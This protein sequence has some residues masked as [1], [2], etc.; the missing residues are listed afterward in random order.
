[1]I[2]DIKWNAFYIGFKLIK[3]GETEISQPQVTKH[4]LLY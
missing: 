3:W 2:K 4:F 1:M